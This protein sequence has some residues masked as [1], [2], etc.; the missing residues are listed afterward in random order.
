MSL[1]GAKKVDKDDQQYVLDAFQDL[2]LEDA[3]YEDEE[4]EENPDEVRVAQVI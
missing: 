1:K 4:E 3:V 2:T